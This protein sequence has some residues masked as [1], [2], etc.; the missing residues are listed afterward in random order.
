MISNEKYKKLGVIGGMGPKAT[1]LF[2]G[3][4]IDKTDADKDQDHIPMVVLNDTTIPDRTVAI[5]S[6]D[7]AEVLGKLVDDAKLLEAT[8]CKAIAIPCNTSHYFID[9]VQ[10]EVE[11][12]IINMIKETVKYIFSKKKNIRKV[13]ILATDGTINVG[14]YQKECEI[15]D[16]ESYIPS[17]EKQAMVMDI[18]YNQVKRGKIGDYDMFLE[19]EKELKDAECDGAILA[20]TELSCLREQHNL[21]D[22]YIDAMDVL[23]NKSIEMCSKN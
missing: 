19:I 11:I 20:C 5:L 2:M 21:S 7:E 14:V 6:G 17:K 18:I 3:M 16:I 15:L 12:P 9:K 1:Q 22:F 4:V 23:V 8:G 13:A 10:D